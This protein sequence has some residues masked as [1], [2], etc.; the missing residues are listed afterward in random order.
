M[1]AAREVFLQAA[2]VLF[3]AASLRRRLG[4]AGCA[5]LRV[6]RTALPPSCACVAATGS[7]AAFSASARAVPA[8]SRC[9]TTQMLL[10][11]D[12]QRRVARQLTRRAAEDYGMAEAAER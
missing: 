5:A 7:G 10:C 9:A 4:F 12:G 11:A 2:P 1:H 8:L 6:R 3:F